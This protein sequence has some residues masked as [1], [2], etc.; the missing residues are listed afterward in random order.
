LAS[1]KLHFESLE[2]RDLL[3]VMRIVDWNTLNGPNDA[4]GDANFQI[5]LQAIGNETIQGNTQRI[6]VLALQETD[7]AGPGGNS[8]ERVQ[9][10]MNGLYPFANY[11]YVVTAIDG[12]GD[13]TGFVFDTTSVSLLDSTTVGSG[14]LTHNVARAKFRPV[15]TFGESDFYIYSIHL[16]SGT[17]AG[18]ATLRASEAAFL[19]ADADALGEGT[20][21]L[22]V[23]DFNMK[24]STESAY[25]NLRMSGAGQM[26]DVAN[27]TEN[28]TWNG[29]LAF[30][31]LH[32][33]DPRT[34]MD[35]RFDIQFGSNEVF[36]GVGFEYVA[37]SYHVFGNNG[38]HTMFQSITTGTGASA[39][40]LSALVAASDHLPVVADYQVIVSTPNVRIRETL[41]GTK[42]AE[43]S[44]YDTYQVVLDTVPAA[45]VSITVTPNSQLDLGNGPGVA[46]VLTFTPANALTPQ[47]IA[48]YAVDDAAGEGTHNSVITHTSASADAAYNALSIVN[49]NVTILDNDAPTIVIN[50]LDSDQTSTDTQEFIEL[51]DG[52][53]GNVSLTGY[54]LVFYN[55]ADA[56]N[57]S[58]RTIDLT[59]KTT[60]A[61]GFFVVG[62]AGVTP[63]PG[64]TFPDNTLQNGADGV[65]LYFAAASAFPNNTVPVAGDS[66]LRDAIVYGTGQATDTDL[67]DILTPGQ[68]QANENENSA[69]TTQSLSRRPDGGAPYQSQLFVAQTPTPGT[70]NV[71]PPYGVQFIQSGVRVD[72]EEG[73]A[74]D[75]YQIALQTIP[76]SNVTITVTPDGQSNLGAGPGVPI[77]LVFTPANALI[78]QTILVTAVDDGVVE[79]NHV[80]VIAHAATS[81][82]SS[83]N[84][85]PISNVVA[86]IVDNDVPPP[87]LVVISEI[88]YNPATNEG[89]AASPEW[90]EIVNLG[91]TPV[92]LSGWLFDDEDATNWGPIPSGTILNP[93]QIAVFF[94]TTFTTAAAFRSAWAVPSGAL[95]VGITWGNL[96]NNPSPTNEILQL[97]NNVGQVMDTVNYDDT[98][99]W[100]AAADG[101][102]IYLK[103]LAADND[104]GANWARSTTV[105][106]AVSPTGGLYSASDV[107]S[108]G[109]IFLAGDYNLNGAV[110]S[111]DYVLWRKTLGQTG[112]NLPADGSGPTPGTPNG[113]VDQADYTF[114]RSNSGAVGVP[115]G[116]LGVGSGD[117]AGEGASSLLADATSVSILT[118]M[119]A[120]AESAPPASTSSLDAEPMDVFDLST[121]AWGLAPKSHP[122]MRSTRHPWSDTA[123]DLLLSLATHGNSTRM[124]D[125]SGELRDAAEVESCDA[126]DELF[127]AFGE[128]DDLLASHS[129]ALL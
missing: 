5:V 84:G 25:A 106:K 109:R 54:I 115:N 76:T 13:S 21:V 45:N 99:P 6:D 31:S 92:N 78:P 117:G 16:K 3:A 56:T 60:D 87:V 116:G 105:A 27:A 124:L 36:D 28:V 7:P 125:H 91:T 103:N 74:T 2:R 113:V 34:N 22:F 64:I 75:S 100:P 114:W 20:N 129:A 89:G 18:D 110:D 61:N 81:A 41:G 58:Y 80:S 48:V 101:P 52:G 8:I 66:R 35:D 118:P 44:F 93:N 62:N 59:G 55:G 53:V 102:S 96:A 4:A 68:I 88:M 15:A 123:T 98:S 120:A 46:K 85:L 39:T 83:Y 90:I 23:G 107:G 50:E 42:V 95:V 33:Q 79:G 71:P 40:V 72:L 63:T 29:N 108:P 119:I 94:D 51:Y 24:G 30:K 65:G 26:F 127:A 19:R 121:T 82:D 32:S 111:A 14:T 49:V 1:R 17:T 112:A 77:V 128:D 37:N 67:I 11:E 86:N 104:N 57:R 9:T 70:F 69:G 122:A 126:V 38:S 73:G 47:T 43:G 97:F 10:I 12:G